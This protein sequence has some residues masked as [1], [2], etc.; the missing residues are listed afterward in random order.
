MNNPTAAERDFIAVAKLFGHFAEIVHEAYQALTNTQRSWLLILDNADDLDFDYQ[1]YFPPGNYSA[2]LIT[3]RV[4]KCRMYN[5]DAFEA[6]EG[7]EKEDSKNL[8]LKAA[9][10]PQES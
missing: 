5:P 3:T 1:V 4:S 8:L 2:V 10:L 9:R 6:L 7:L